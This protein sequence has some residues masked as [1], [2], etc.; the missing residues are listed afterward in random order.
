MA[1]VV[2]FQTTSLRTCY[3]ADFHEC[4]SERLTFSLLPKQSSTFWASLL[5]VLA[6]FVVVSRFPN[7]GFMMPACTATLSGFEPLSTPRSPLCMHSLSSASLASPPELRP[8]APLAL[9]AVQFHLVTYWE[10][11]VKKRIQPRGSFHLF[12]VIFL[13]SDFIT[14][15]KGWNE[16]VEH[17]EQLPSNIPEPFP[18]LNYGCS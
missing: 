10:R 6:I 15:I 8:V 14:V 7:P 4:L 13:E 18:E 5:I 11:G 9:G 3:S 17:L 2:C 16:F 12:R 1:V